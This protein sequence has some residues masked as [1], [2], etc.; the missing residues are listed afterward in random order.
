MARWAEWKGRGKVGWQCGGY[1]LLPPG[2]VADA[3]NYGYIIARMRFAI[4]LAPGAARELRALPAHIR[5]RVRDAIER[6]L[7][8]EP[9]KVSQ[10]RIKRLRG[11]SRPQFRLRVDDTR[12][13]YDVTD[14][15]VE[16]LAIVS[17][18]QAASWLAASG[19]PGPAGQ[20]EG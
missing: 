6:H 18:A 2:M 13:F 8:H 7:R 4:V 14:E 1:G 3:G 15:A 19:E 5:A 12:V 10:S 17:K 11:L 20:G 16:I 9:A